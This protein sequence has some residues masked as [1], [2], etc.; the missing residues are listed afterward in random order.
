MNVA[1]LA[2]SSSQAFQPSGSSSVSVE[3]LVVVGQMYEYVVLSSLTSMTL[4]LPRNRPRTDGCPG[5][6]DEKI[7]LNPVSEYEYVGRDV[8]D[9]VAVVTDEDVTDM[10][11]SVLVA[12]LDCIVEPATRAARL[13]KGIALAIISG[14]WSD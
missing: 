7:G 6:R 4:A 12:K 2:Y 5:G 3:I 11:P 1:T 9:G 10:N 13:M 14:K 8:M